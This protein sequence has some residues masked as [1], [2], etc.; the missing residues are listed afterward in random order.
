M[1]KMVGIQVH[2]GS[3]GRGELRT[4]I[5][6]ND[7]NVR[8]IEADLQRVGAIQQKDIRVHIVHWHPAIELEVTA[9]SQNSIA[10]RRDQ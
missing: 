9:E 3:A 8:A 4:A 10:K 6:G 5:V 7:V 1:I 2:G